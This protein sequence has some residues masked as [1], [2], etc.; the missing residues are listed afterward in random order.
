MPYFHALLFA[1]PRSQ[2]E[3]LSNALKAEFTGEKR[4]QHLAISNL[5]FWLLPPKRVTSKQ[6]GGEWKSSG[7]KWSSGWEEASKRSHGPCHRQTVSD[8]TLELDKWH[9]WDKLISY[10]TTNRQNRYQLLLWWKGI[11][12]TQINCIP[13]T[14]T[15][16]KHYDCRMMCSDLQAI[17]GEQARRQNAWKW[18]NAPLPIKGHWGGCY[19]K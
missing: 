13:G 9:M 5:L 1:F 7:R 2:M 8:V 15:S 14:T 6:H 16:S 4:R 10:L 19:P 3:F 11:I 17:A 18:R 12:W